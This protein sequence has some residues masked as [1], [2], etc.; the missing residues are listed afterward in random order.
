MNMKFTTLL[1]IS[2]KAGS[3]NLVNIDLLEQKKH[4]VGCLFN[5][6]KIFSTSLCGSE[7]NDNLT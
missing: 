5:S 1:I 4:Q 7:L 3:F 2:V 6:F